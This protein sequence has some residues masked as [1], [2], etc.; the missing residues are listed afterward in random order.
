M[1]S[2][3]KQHDFAAGGGLLAGL[4]FVDEHERVVGVDAG[5][6]DT[7]PA[8]AAGVDEPCRR[9]FE[10]AVRES[11][12]ADLGVAAD[13]VFALLGADDGVFEEAADVA[14]GLGVGEF[15][16]ANLAHPIEHGAGAGVIDAEAF[17]MAGEV[18]VADVGAPVFGQRKAH[19][20]D[21]G[22]AF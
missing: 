19:V 16:A 14:H 22:F 10:G 20:G 9:E 4:S 8:P 2:F 5:V 18:G 6:A 21:E 7:A 13:D 11:V 3:G 15:G 17:G 1:D 12:V